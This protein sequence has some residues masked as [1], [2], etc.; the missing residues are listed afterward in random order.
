M[1]ALPCMRL[2]LTLDAF[3]ENLETLDVS[4]N[5]IESLDSIEGLVNL[6]VLILGNNRMRPEDSLW[7][8]LSL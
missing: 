5:R 8:N 7:E 3:R 2:V 1:S 6:R 4:Y